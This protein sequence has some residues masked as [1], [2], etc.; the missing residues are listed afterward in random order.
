MY[1]THLFKQTSIA[2]LTNLIR[3]VIDSNKLSYPPPSF[4][5]AQ[6]DVILRRQR[7]RPRQGGGV[8]ST[9]IPSRFRHL[10]NT[11]EF[12]G[13]GTMSRIELQ[14]PELSQGQKDVQDMRRVTL[15]QFAASA[16]AG[17]SILGGVF[18]TLPAV[19]AVAGVL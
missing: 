18:Y 19:V 12:A 3:F 5:S 7:Q 15:G 1:E 17:N 6:F 10:Q 13:W 2:P 9:S 4:K 16:I 11:L 14:E 8:K